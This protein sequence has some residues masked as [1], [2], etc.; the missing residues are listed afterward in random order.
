MKQKNPEKKFRQEKILSQHAEP[1]LHC[2]A[3]VL[4]GLKPNF[5]I[6]KIFRSAQAFGAREMALVG[7]NFFDPYPAK[8]AFKQTRSRSFETFADCH[9]SLSSEGYVFYALDPQGEEVLD[10]CELPEKT[11]FVLGHE[12]FGLSFD[13]ADFPDLRRLRIRQWG[14]V[15]SLNVAVAASL[16][17]YEHCRRWAAEK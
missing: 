11:A 10:R 7:I 16:A 6:G 13:P 14:Q 2:F 17:M 15:E 5:N 3:V 12:E 8:G 4:D 9:Q 1:G